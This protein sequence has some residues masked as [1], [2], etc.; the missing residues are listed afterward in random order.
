MARRIVRVS[1]KEMNFLFRL[2]QGSPTNYEL[3][4]TNYSYTLPQ[5]SMQIDN[6]LI[7]QNSCWSDWRI[8]T[9]QRYIEILKAFP[10]VR[11]VA[12]TGASAMKGVRPHDDIDLC[13]VTKHK[14]LWTSRFFVV[15]LAKI[16]KI[17]TKFGVCLNLFF[18]EAD[19]K[20]QTHKQTS[21]V[22]HEILQMKPI[23][24][25]DNVY[26]QFLYE[27]EWI[28]AFFPNANQSVILGTEGTP[29]SMILDASSPARLTRM[30]VWNPI[31]RF[32]KHIQ[33]P[34]IHRNKTALYITSTQLW[35]FK[36]DF[37]KKLKR[38][39]LS[40]NF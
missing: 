6:K 18:D 21:Y 4:T 33:L 31:E 25:K 10:L 7:M 22:G 37:E 11:F 8:K 2:S 17:H 26:R 32:L 9:F 1:Q 24:D 3:R 14:A 23:I 5:Y 29:E 16:L 38:N 34:L 39:G 20:V 36:S 30:T 15:I 27:N 12:I 40:T 35:L 28:Y 13:I 19:L